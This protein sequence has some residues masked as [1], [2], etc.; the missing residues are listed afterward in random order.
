MP[1]WLP[2]IVTMLTASTCEAASQANASGN[3]QVACSEV[4]SRSDDPI[5]REGIVQWVAGY[6]T[7]L[8][9][10]LT[11]AEGEARNLF[12]YLDAGDE[13]WAEVHLRC[14]VAHD[15]T[16]MDVARAM[17]REFPELELN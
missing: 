15:T 12:A 3:W 16:L 10:G 1:R 7:G 9:D 6:W 17:F 2:L 11:S 8:D 4:V 13:L 14:R 5:F